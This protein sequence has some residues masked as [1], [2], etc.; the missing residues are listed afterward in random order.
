MDRREFFQAGLATAFAVQLASDALIGQT[1]AA[2]GGKLKLAINSRH[3][4]WLR[5]ADEVAEAA[6]EMGF[7]G[8]DLTV[9]PHPG[10]VDPAR[11]A[12]DLPAFVNAIRKNGLEV[13][14]ITCPITDADSPNAEALLGAA[15]AA[16][17]THYAC[18]PFRYDETKPIQPQLD[19]LKPR[20]EKL[21]KLNER[22]KLKAMYRTVAGSANVGSAVWDFLSVLRN[23]DPAWVSFQYDLAEMTLA[24]GGGTWALNL[25]AAGPY[26]GGV[27]LDDGIVETTFV[28]KG[29]G[30]FTGSPAPAGGRAGGGRG[31]GAAGASGGGGGF[32]GPGGP[33]GGAPPGA[34]DFAGGAGSGGAAPGLGGG[35]AGASGGRGGRGGGGRGGGG[36]GGGVRGAVAPPPWHNR[37]VPLGTGMAGLSPMAGILKEIIFSGPVEIQAEYPNGGAE[38]GDDHITLPREQVIGNMKRDLLSVR[39]AWAASGLL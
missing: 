24:G 20:V 38:N 15:H 19:A 16:G 21:A 6:S 31:R 33:G 3:L 13:A 23:F 25:K 12:T 32:G 8:V 11:A 37:P 4:Q 39:A 34:E 2:A 36:A 1:A 10:H 29:G 9:Q 5:S 14:A 22:Y 7:A 35:A 26:I 17:L 28:V 30:P 27:T 18:A